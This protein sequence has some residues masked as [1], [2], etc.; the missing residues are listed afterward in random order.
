ME[1]LYIKHKQLVRNYIDLFF[2]FSF[3]RRPTFLTHDSGLVT[4]KKKEQSHKGGRRRVGPVSQTGGERESTESRGQ[5]Q[6]KTGVQEK[7]G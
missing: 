4:T 1:L 2:L 3:T 7:Y 6:G 5:D